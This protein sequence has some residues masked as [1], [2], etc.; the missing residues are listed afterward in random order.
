MKSIH[1]RSEKENAFYE[2]LARS[3]KVLSKAFRFWIRTSRR[4]NL[5]SFLQM[6]IIEQILLINR[7]RFFNALLNEVF[8]RKFAFQERGRL[9]RRRKKIFP[10]IF[11]P[12]R[13]KRM[14]KSQYLARKKR[15]FVKIWKRF[16]VKKLKIRFHEKS[17]LRDKSFSL[18][19]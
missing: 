14:N 9:E 12:W 17:F 1:C 6:I 19:A 11:P 15:I 13:N 2:S 18:F 5:S 3:K 16:S 7:L 8:E 4:P 10:K